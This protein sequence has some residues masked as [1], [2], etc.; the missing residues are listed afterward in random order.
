MRFY[1]KK[2][3]LKPFRRS[4]AAATSFGQTIAA[5]KVV[6]MYNMFCVSTNGS[7]FSI[8]YWG[9]KLSNM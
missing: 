8:T 6:A 4:K 9:Q 1:K 2:K 5:K 7:N 3:N